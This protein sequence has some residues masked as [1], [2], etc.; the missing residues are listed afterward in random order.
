MGHGWSVNAVGIQDRAVLA[1]LE[2]KGVPI[3]G[4][5]QRFTEHGVNL[6][7]DLP[8]FLQPYE[9]KI[10]KLDPKIFAAIFRD[11]DVLI[12]SLRRRGVIRALDGLPLT[13]IGFGW[14]T[15][16]G[17]GSARIMPPA[18]YRDCEAICSNYQM[19]LHTSHLQSHAT[20][21]RVLHAML[22]GQGVLAETT[23]YLEAEASKGY[24]ALFS[25]NA[26]NV[27]QVYSELLNDDNRRFAM[28]Q[29]ALKTISTA[30]PMEQA[31]A[32][33]IIEILRQRGLLH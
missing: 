4:F 18:D 27:A 30:P 20:H 7:E 25:S 32:D 8:A 26:A 31:A 6:V 5:I 22:V 11:S 14:D 2:H 28:A 19:R 3:S 17:L 33:S 10:G 1:A 12:R 23:P 24:L 15:C 9:N 16:R 21:D 29:A 13:I